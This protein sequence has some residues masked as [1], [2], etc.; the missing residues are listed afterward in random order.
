[1]QRCSVLV[2][3]LLAFAMYVS[4]QSLYPVS[5]G[6][7]IKCSAMIEMPKGYI[8]GICMMYNDGTEI[9]G[10]I[11]N[12]FGISAIDFTYSIAKD[13]VKLHDVLPMLN[14]WYIKKLLRSDLRKVLHNLRQGACEYRNEKYK[15]DYKFSKLTN[16]SEE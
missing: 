12:E 6:D 3:M 8:S 13:K 14:R 11:F 1:M 9:K 7:K 15:I 16:D 10:S 4:A 2:S 5:A